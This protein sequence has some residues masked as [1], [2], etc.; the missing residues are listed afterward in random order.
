MLKVEFF[1]QLSFIFNQLLFY[2]FNGTN[3]IFLKTV[4]VSAIIL[5]QMK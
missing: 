5:M 1:N 2:W 4:L 3:F